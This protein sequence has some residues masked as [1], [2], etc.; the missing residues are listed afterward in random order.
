MKEFSESAKRASGLAPAPARIISDSVHA[1]ALSGIAVFLILVC[2]FG[3]WAA[4]VKLAGAVISQGTVVVDSSVKKVQHPTGG[5]VGEI[6]VRDGDR[7]EAGQLL[8]RLDETMTRA[9]L[10]VIVR[11]IDELA[12]RRARLIAELDGHDTIEFP[13][14]GDRHNDQ[15]TAD[16]VRSERG[17]FE[18]RR[19]GLKGKKSQLSEQIQQLNEQTRGLSAQVAAKDREIELIHA[20][21]AGLEILEK[22]DLVSSTR[23][24][25]S[26]REAARVEGER[27]ALI[28]SIAQ[29][30]GKVSE[31]ELEII[32]LD[33]DLKTDVS[34]DLRETQAKL[35]E[36]GERRIAAEDQLKRVDL[37]SPQDGIVHQLSVHT[38]GGVV[39]PG[40]PVMLIVPAGDA[41]VIE[42]KILPQDIDNV[43]QGQN[44]FIKF[45]AFNQQTT[46]EFNGVVDRVAADLTTDPKLNLSYFV[47]RISLPS[48]ELK[49]LGGL[50]LVPG[51]PAEVFIRTEERTAL[52]Y[53]MKPLVDQVSR[54]FRD[55]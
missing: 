24:T 16:A 48:D 3:G 17:L 6:Q 39:S 26:R 40:E 27:G 23:I 32:Q 37:R 20:E 49:R 35:A 15:P 8:L 51:M 5:V 18:S 21:L 43:R 42:A 55:G 4:T 22:K 28:A 19:L 9:N 12:I 47:A 13:D 1:Y 44:A 46:P 53:L 36:L 29:A 10:L 30:K 41:L 11:Q 31:T 25:S 45:S 54:A 33:Q 14:L 38:I 34:R 2:G 7:V 50:K 52:S